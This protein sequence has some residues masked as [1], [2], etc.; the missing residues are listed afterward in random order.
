MVP[1]H[2]RLTST[3]VVPSRVY[4]IAKDYNGQKLLR[5][6]D[7]EAGAPDMEQDREQD[8]EQAQLRDLAVELALG[9]GKLIL[10]M[11]P[12]GITAK[13]TPTDLVS[14]VDRA[15]EHYIVSRL[16]AARPDDSILAEEGS[17]SQGTSGITWVID[18]LDGTINFLYKIPQWCVSIGVESSFHLGVIYDPVKD[19]MFSDAAPG[20]PSAKTELA[21]CLIGTGFAYAASTRI[22]Q[23]KVL[24]RVLPNVRDIR[25][26]GSCALDLAWVACGRLDGF[27]EDGTNR[28]DISAGIAIVEAAG[29][30]VFTKGQ[31]TIAAGNRELLDKLTRLVL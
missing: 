4:R 31:M 19:E 21:D 27:F 25:R 16:R 24:T 1:K 6:G 17:V 3:P 2:S 12:S 15:A 13:S 7:M 20:T 23:A 11:A 14:D 28:W 29:G 22:A 26:V 18:P 10:G 5:L 9:A 30:A 8:S